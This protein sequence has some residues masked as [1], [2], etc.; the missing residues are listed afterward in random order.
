[1]LNSTHGDQ[2]SGQ[3]L[4]SSDAEDLEIRQLRREF[5]DQL[6]YV[7]DHVKG[8]ATVTA[9]ALEST[10]QGVVFWAAANE[11]P[12]RLVA[13]FLRGLLK[14]LNQLYDSDQDV[15]E[16]LEDRILD[17]II[18]FNLKRIKTYWDLLQKPL[19][20]CLKILSRAGNTEGQFVQSIHGHVS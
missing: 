16:L 7:C 17:K 8:G 2:I 12:E 1:M 13:P 9:L 4:E 6:A 14:D 10:P 18:D 20:C 11:T 5:L 3:P 15:A 19:R